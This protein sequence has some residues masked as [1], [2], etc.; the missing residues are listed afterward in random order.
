MIYQQLVLPLFYVQDETTFAHYYPGKNTQLIEYLKNAALNEREAFLYLWGASGVGKTHLLQA[1]CHWAY[2]VG[3]SCTYIPFS[4]M[5][6]FTPDIFEGLEK[7]QLVCIDDAH[8]IA[9]DP[10]WEEAF[11][12]FF[13]RMQAA[14]SHL[15]VAAESIPQDLGMVL[16]DLVSRLSWG[17]TFQV[18]FLSDEEKMAA[19]QQRAE[20]RGM[21][22]SEEVA[23]YILRYYPRDLLS[24]FKALDLLDKASLAEQRR[25][26][27][28][29]VK[30]VLGIS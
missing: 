22:L 2:A 3:I 21:H 11:F 15:V 19:L 8:K 13:N 10:V 29:F 26:T 27:K 6:A 9:G 30:E 17:L 25:L 1:C 18:Q 16:P 7:L 24:M 12:H 28:P 14:G 23:Q 5:K 20:E 4:E